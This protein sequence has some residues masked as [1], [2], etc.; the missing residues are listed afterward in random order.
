MSRLLVIRHGPAGDRDV[1]AKTGK[2]DSERPLTTE[3]KA[4][5][6][7]AARGL[8]AIVPH[9]DILASSPYVRAHQTAKIVAGAYEGLD[10]QLLEALIPDGSRSDILRWL[11]TAP[12]NA[13]V[14][15]AGHESD[16]SELIA[17]L[18]TG[19][20]KPWL[21]LKKGGACLIAYDGLPP[22]RPP[23]GRM[24]WCLTRG[25]LERVGR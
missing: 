21:E 3:G 5:M 10:V 22:A 13:T 24:E 17:W 2:D 25:Q 18:L 15:I 9:I 7:R 20:A 4:K 23:A 8:R 11:R 12:D 16:L 19:S 1:W 14:A 6:R